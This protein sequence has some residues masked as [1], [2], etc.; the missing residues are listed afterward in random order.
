[1][2]ILIHR[3]DLQVLQLPQRRVPILT[4]VEDHGHDALRVSRL[5]V[6]AGPSDAHEEALRQEASRDAHQVLQLPLAVR[7]LPGVFRGIAHHGAIHDTNGLKA[8]K[9][10][11]ESEGKGLV[12]DDQVQKGA[13]L[14][15]PRHLGELPRSLDSMSLQQSAGC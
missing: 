13:L 15:F 14:R 3:Q 12:G 9:K 8:S 11:K 5:R 7:D 4:A 2:S 6:A 10:R 1:M